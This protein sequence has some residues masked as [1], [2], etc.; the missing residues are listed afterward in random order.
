MYFPN[1]DHFKLRKLAI[2]KSNFLAKPTIEKTKLKTEDLEEIEQLD[3]EG[4]VDQVE[5][6][7]EIDDLDL[8]SQLSTQNTRPKRKRCEKKCPCCKGIFYILILFI[9]NFI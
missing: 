8:E 6:I 4:D 5:I 1:L 7:L 9:N 3:Q 2:K